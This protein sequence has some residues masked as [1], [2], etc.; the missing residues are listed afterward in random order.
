[1][2]NTTNSPPIDASEATRTQAEQF[3]LFFSKLAQQ[4]MVNREN[5]NNTKATFS[6]TQRSQILTWLRSPESNSSAKGLRNSSTFMLMRSPQYRRLC[7]HYAFTPMWCYTL[8]PVGY[9]PTKVKPETLRK[10]YFKTA[11]LLENMNLKHE[12]QKAS[13]IAWTEGVLYGL[14]WATNTSFFIQRINPDYC[15]ITS[16]TDGCF[17]YSIDMSQI[18][19]ADLFK[20]PDIVTTM[21]NEYKNTGVKLQEV[22]DEYSFCLKIDE[23]E[24]TYVVPPFASAL[25]YLYDIDSYVALASDRDEIQNYK[26][27]CL[28]I[29]VDDA[30]MPTVDEPLVE[31]YYQQVTNN[32]PEAIGVVASPFEI[33]P[34]DFVKNN[35]S[36]DNDLIATSEEHFWSST[37]TSYLLFGSPKNSTSRGIEMSIQADECSMFAAMNQCERLINRYLKCQSGTSKFKINFLPVTRFNWDKMLAKYVE[38]T[39]YGIPVKSAVCAIMGMQPADIPGMD[40]IEKEYL[41]VLDLTPMASTHTQSSTSAGRPTN[42][43]QG[44]PLSD[45]GEQTKDDDENANR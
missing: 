17:S 22:P 24:P 13:L 11:A 6:N 8:S 19:E 3:A 1:M 26:A 45:A 15:T 7:Q 14:I 2:D 43:S 34:I 23:A 4:Q 27:L 35:V 32:I 37:G 21:W 10:Q 41:G 9:D 18:R 31:Q 33:T 44:E 30:G 20:Y 28:K 29:P 39:T 25:P 16:V 36:N 42:E 5:N 12:M 40:M 38:L